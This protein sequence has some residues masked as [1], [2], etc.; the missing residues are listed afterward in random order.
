MKIRR[1]D[2]IIYGFDASHWNG[3]I[4]TKAAHD[5]GFTFAFGKCTDG[6][7]YGYKDGLIH[8]HVLR[9]KMG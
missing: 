6:V 1:Y 8:S 7:S 3:R 9:V 5:G 4:D 2:G